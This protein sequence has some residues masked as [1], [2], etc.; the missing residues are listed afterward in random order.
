MFKGD[1]QKF[2]R[3]VNKFGMRP[4]VRSSGHDYIGRSAGDDTCNLSFEKFRERSVNLSDSES[5]TGSSITVTSGN[6]WLDV[7]KEV[8]W[9]PSIS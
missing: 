6:S 9:P 2:A 8:S 3:F 5:S 4:T 7:Y 1:V